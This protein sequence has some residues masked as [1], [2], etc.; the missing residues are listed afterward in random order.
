MTVNFDFIRFNRVTVECLVVRSYVY[1]N[2]TID[3]FSRGTR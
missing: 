2:L 1:V 3:T